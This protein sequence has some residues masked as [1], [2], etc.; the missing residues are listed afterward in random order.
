MRQGVGVVIAILLAKSPLTAVGIGQY[1]QLLYVGALLTS[2][3]LT[4]LVQALLARYA[5]LSE[6]KQQSFL[7][8]AYLVVFTL[9]TLLAL[10]AWSFQRWWL[11]VLVGQSQL[12]G[13]LPFLIYLALN[14]PIFLLDNYYLLLKRP[15]ELLGF[16]IISHGLQLPFL[17]L[18]IYL[19][20]GLIGGL[21]GLVF[22]A[23]LRQVWMLSRIATVVRWSFDKPI[24]RA[25]V[26]AAFPLVLYALVGTLSVSFDSW[27]VNWAYEGDKRTFAI[28][29]YGA[30]EFPLAMALSAA[31]GAAMLPA[32]SKDLAVGTSELR[33][34]SLRLFHL[35]FPLTIALVLSSDWWFPRLFSPAFAESAPLFNVFMLITVSRL[36]FSRTVLVA[37]DENRFVFY[38]SLVELAFNIVLGLVLVGRMGLLGVAWATVA[39]YTLE[40]LLLCGYLYYRY[41]LSPKAYIP[42]GWLLLY[43]GLLL[44]SVLIS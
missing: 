12:G 5:Q 28:F 3:W 21:W 7:G 10:L 31:F 38:S 37:L 2:F 43:S 13:L 39:A 30:R 23:G 36:V 29:R 32:L 14:L 34:R 4:G 1:E 27:L 24:A 20:Y 17:L 18:P 8:L 41:R 9:G 33:R 35:L 16:A 44:L 19:G 15:K 11:P 25:W 26:T 40:K 22:L 6:D 42:M